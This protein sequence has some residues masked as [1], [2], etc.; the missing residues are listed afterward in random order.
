MS[1]PR[2]TAVPKPE[3]LAAPAPI[4]P[5]VAA[6]EAPIPAAP[7]QPE[8]TGAESAPAPV[9]AAT[10]AEVAP[11]PVD[12]SPEV[13]PWASGIVLRVKGPAKGRWRAGRHFGPE[14]V[15][16]PAEDLTEEDVQKLHGDP[17]LTCVVIGGDD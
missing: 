11:A 15:D 4:A 14:A 16:I 12:T 3:T 1:R 6:T 8:T 10:A 5:V 13:A 9:S 17:E 2:K 7:P